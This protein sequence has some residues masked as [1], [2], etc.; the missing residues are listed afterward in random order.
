MGRMTVPKGACVAAAML[1]AVSVRAAVAAAEPP[2]GYVSEVLPN[3]LSVSIVPD[4]ANTVV[5][6][7][8]WYH[9]GSANEDAGSRGLAHLFEH[10]MFGET[11]NR[12]KEDYSD[13]HHRHGGE[14]N[15]YTSFDEIGRAHV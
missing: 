10:L 7:Q 12:P 9:V 11:T 2:P 8:V 13:Y 6:T 1:L 3:G 4:P 15:A 14:E 5:S